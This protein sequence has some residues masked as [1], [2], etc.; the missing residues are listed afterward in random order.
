MEATAHEIGPITEKLGV[1]SAALVIAPLKRRAAN[2]ALGHHCDLPNGHSKGR[3]G[4]L[5][6]SVFRVRKC[7]FFPFGTANNL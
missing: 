2:T 5:K 7:F 4:V 1:R 3:F 6:V